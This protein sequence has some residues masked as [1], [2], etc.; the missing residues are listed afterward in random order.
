MLAARLEV[1]L[2][3]L[4]SILVGEDPVLLRLRF[5]PV[6]I[7]GE[8]IRSVLLVCD[9]HLLGPRPMVQGRKT[10]PGDLEIHLWQFFVRP[11][12]GGKKD[13]LVGRGALARNEELDSFLVQ[14]GILH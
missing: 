10:D 14:H 7:G 12:P 3:I 5:V 13:P 4:E 8:Q 9:A 11:R 2:Q 6:R 1:G